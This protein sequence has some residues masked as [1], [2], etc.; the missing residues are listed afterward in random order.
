MKPAE[1]LF[2]LGNEADL[3]TPTSTQKYALGSVIS[4]IDPTVKAVKKYMYVYAPSQCTIKVPYMITWTG[5]TGQ[6]VEAV[7]V[8]TLATPGMI[9]GVPPATITATY[10]G[11]IQIEGLCS[12]NGTFTDTYFVTVLNSGPTVFADDDG[13]QP[14]LTD[15]SMGIAVG[16]GTGTDGTVLLLGRPATVRAS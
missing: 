15:S 13:S 3:T 8:A 16:A 12:A 10:Y 5:T 7:T 11:F 6:E 1:I 14:V 2:G 4:I 9:V